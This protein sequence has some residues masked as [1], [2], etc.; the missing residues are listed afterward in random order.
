MSFVSDILPD[1]LST[2]P[3]VTPTCD[4]PLLEGD[5]ATIVSTSIF[6]LIT[7]I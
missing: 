1:L 7:Q 4:C 2:T 5:E 6:S 3:D